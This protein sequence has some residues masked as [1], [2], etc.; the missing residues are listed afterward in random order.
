[1]YQQISSTPIRKLRVSGVVGVI[2]APIFTFIALR[3]G[4]PAVSA[5]DVDTLV[6][7]GHALY[8]AAGALVTWIT[9]Y[10][11]RPSATDAPVR[12]R[13]TPP[14]QGGPGGRVY[15]TLVALALVLMPGWATAQT[16][17]ILAADHGVVARAD[18]DNRAALQRAFDAARDAYQ[19]SVD[20]VY[21]DLPCHPPHRIS[22]QAIGYTGEIVVYLGTI[23]RGC[24]GTYLAEAEGAKLREDD[25]AGVLYRPVREVADL[26]RPETRLRVLDG[27][28]TPTSKHRLRSWGGAGIVGLR[29]LVLDGNIEG[30]MAQFV[31][32]PNKE[33]YFRNSPG[34]SGFVVNDHDGARFSPV[35]VGDGGL[36]NRPLVP[37]TFVFVDRVSVGGYAATGLLGHRC[38]LWRL[39]EV[40][41]GNTLYNH[42]LY[43]TP[44]LASRSVA[45]RPDWPYL[46]ERHPGGTHRNLTLY[47]YAWT[48]WIAQT[49]H[50][51]NFVYEH[52]AR[53]PIGRNGWE[54][55]NLRGAYLSLNSGYIDTRAE[56][57][58]PF[59]ALVRAE[60]RSDVRARRLVWA[61]SVPPERVLSSVSWQGEV[62]DLVMA[63]PPPREMIR[64]GSLDA[65]GRPCPTCAFRPET[66]LWEPLHERRDAVLTTG[67]RP[68]LA[69]PS[70]PSSFA[71]EHRWDRFRD[72]RLVCRELRTGRFA[73][74]E[75][76]EGL[77]QP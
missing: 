70:Q 71:P 64:L 67:W 39:R 40:R 10:R 63:G 1:M 76:C 75:R 27:S 44:S 68:P 51:E 19:A 58:P 30:N 50:V 2:L 13:R 74:R 66:S 55:I 48:H 6:A 62:A 42:T 9:A 26:G 61:T 38:A 32:H 16:V 43:S 35:C 11:A 23:I 57:G 52:P 72:G 65:L 36:M 22:G 20:T 7:L 46:S 14:D 21:V 28:I 4:L 34:H 29:D 3:F 73:P 31:L 24:G 47:G 59:Q 8:M 77:A 17:T 49:D 53:S 37:G 45:T 5:E 12:E 18:V 56:G 69:T 41:A 54:L 33:G 15:G 60:G 25:R